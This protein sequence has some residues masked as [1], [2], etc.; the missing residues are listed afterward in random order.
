MARHDAIS[1][2]NS[3]ENRSTSYVNINYD[4]SNNKNNS[5]ITELKNKTEQMSTIINLLVFFLIK[6]N[7]SFNIENMFMEHQRT[8]PTR[9][10]IKIFLTQLDIDIMLISE[11]HLKEFFLHGY[12][13][14][15]L[16][17]A[18]HPDGRTHLWHCLE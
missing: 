5:D 15:I 13:T 2:Q 7:N 1:K 18:Q 16:Y 9:S 4:T 14:T 3:T 12:H 17:S 10:R 8:E 6:N 11:T